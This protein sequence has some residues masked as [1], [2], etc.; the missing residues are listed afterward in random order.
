MNLRKRFMANV[1]V[2]ALTTT[3]ALS[4][5]ACSNGSQE[6][7]T[8]A[9]AEAEATTENVEAT[10]E[11]ATEATTEAPSASAFTTVDKTEYP[12][13]ITRAIVNESNC[14]RI[15]DILFCLLL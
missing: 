9:Q 13:F 1:M 11:V 3:M 5:S 6:A 10:T 15:Q 2:A 12:E 4:L 7:T 14:Y 8:S